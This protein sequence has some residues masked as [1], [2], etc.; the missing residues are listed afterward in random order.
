MGLHSKDVQPEQHSAAGVVAYNM[1]SWA[2]IV[3]GLGLASQ[4][5]SKQAER[6]LNA[7]GYQGPT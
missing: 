1:L 6:A 3:S 5:V 2:K 7:P 4:A